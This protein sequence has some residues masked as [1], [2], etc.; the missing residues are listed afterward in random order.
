MVPRAFRWNAIAER[1]A[2]DGHRIDVICSWKPGFTREEQIHGVRVIRTGGTVSEK[3]R[4][5]LRSSAEEGNQLPGADSSGR[6][7]SRKKIVRVLKFAHDMTWKKMYWPDFACLWHISAWRKAKRLM[8]DAR[9]DAVI[10]VSH[11]FSSHLTGVRLKK[12]WPELSWIVDI[13]DPFYFHSMPTNNRLLY[14]GINYWAER[15]VLKRADYVVLN[16]EQTKEMYRSTFQMEPSKMRV[17][18]PLVSTPNTDLIL[19]VQQ[20]GERLRFIFIGTLYRDIRNPQALLKWFEALYRDMQGNVELHF[21]GNV[22]DCAEYFEPYGRY[23]DETLFVHGLVP[24]EQ[25]YSAM[26][27]ADILVNIGNKTPDLLPSKLVEYASTGKPIF[28]LVSIPDDSSVE[29]FR[30]YHDVIHVLEDELTVN[31]DIR[32]KIVHWIHNR[33]SF[34]PN[35]LK[36]FMNQFSVETIAEQYESLLMSSAAERNRNRAVRPTATY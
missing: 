3:L 13:G 36:Q 8:S 10:S 23:K 9:Y 14:N 6:T 2:R 29:F 17:S 5:K 28:N 35:R 26:I 31:A 18:P 11:P 16:T 22:G 30:T 4:S 21:Y 19:P 24:R 15:G 12:K 20:P 7:A 34:E 32:G 25:A 1:W 33:P 27:G